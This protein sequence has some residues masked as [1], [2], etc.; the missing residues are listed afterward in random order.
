MKGKTESEVAQSCPPLRDPMDRSLP[1]SSVHGI[2]QESILEWGGWLD[3]ISAS[4]IH[5]DVGCLPDV[6]ELL[7]GGNYSMSS[8]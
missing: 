1:G 6:Q 7:R 4:P 2:L 3:H 8:Y 5:F